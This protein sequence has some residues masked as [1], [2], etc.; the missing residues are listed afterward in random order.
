M[1]INGMMQCHSRDKP[2]QGGPYTTR[3]AYTTTLLSIRPKEVRSMTYLSFDCDSYITGLNVTFNRTGVHESEQKKHVDCFSWNQ[4]T[5]LVRKL[6][7]ACSMQESTIKH[8]T[9]S[10]GA[11]PSHFCKKTPNSFV[12]LEYYP[13]HLNP[14][15]MVENFQKLLAPGLNSIMAT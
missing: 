6:I 11:I 3:L 8:L 7:L 5:L 14:V 15:R 10:H 12:C 4:M 2:V 13:Q 9:T 1:I